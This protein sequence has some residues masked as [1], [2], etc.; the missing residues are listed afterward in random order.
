MSLDFVLGIVSSLQFALIGRGR[1]KKFPLACSLGGIWQSKK[2]LHL[3]NS[4]EAREK[5]ARFNRHFQFLNPWE[6]KSVPPS[7][8]DQE[9]KMSIF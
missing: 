5:I 9:Q 3:S 1:E 6:E 7:L 2:E 8:E 4:W